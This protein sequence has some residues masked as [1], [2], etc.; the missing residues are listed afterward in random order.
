MRPTDEHFHPPIALRTDRSFAY[1]NRIMGNS[2]L[3]TSGWCINFTYG[4]HSTTFW[5]NLFPVLERETC[6]EVMRKADRASNAWREIMTNEST[7]NFTS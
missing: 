7:S 1:Y 5:H 3:F 2:C 4:L 6:I